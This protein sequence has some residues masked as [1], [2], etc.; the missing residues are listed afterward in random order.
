MNAVK[1]FAD[2][3]GLVIGICNGFQILCETGLLPG[4]LVRNRSLQFRCEQVYLKVPTQDSPFTREIEAGS[5]IRVPIA[6][7]EGCY[8]ADDESLARLQSNDQILFQYVTADGE[9]RGGQPE[10][11]PAQHR[12][13]LQRGPK[14]LRHDTPPGTGQRKHPWRGRWLEDF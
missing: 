9:P 6:H 5:V 12:R 8:F 11:I 3:G 10:R 2:D 13:D 4:A 7:G 1:Q 14:R